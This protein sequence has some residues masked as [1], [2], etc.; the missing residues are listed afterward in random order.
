MNSS[1]S[2]PPPDLAGIITASAPG[3]RRP[4]VW[5]LTATGIILLLCAWLFLGHRG[6]ASHR[7]P[8][9]E[10]EALH[11]SDVRLTITGTGTLQPITQVTVGSELSGLILHV[12]VDTN[13]RV[14]RNQ[15]LAE[16]DTTKLVQQ[17]ENSRASE[18]LAEAAVA[19]A[20]ATVRETEAMRERQRN[21]QQIS[22]GK[23]PSQSDFD[24]AV[25]AADRAEA[26]LK[27]A[28]AQVDQAKAQVRG[29]EYDLD[30]AVIR[31]PIDG[32]VLTRT[33]EPGQTVAASF[34][35]PELFVIAEKLE[36]MTLKVG[37]A[38]ADIGRVKAGDRATFTVDAWPGRLYDA[39]VSKVAFGSAV[40]DN[41]VT[42]QTELEVAN[43]DLSLRPGM[44]A[45]ADIRVAEAH[46][47]FVVS[48]A[49]LRFDPAA[50]RAALA[51]LQAAKAAGNSSLLPNPSSQAGRAPVP[52]SQD[53]INLPGVARI[54]VLQAGRPVPIPVQLGI[55]DGRFTEIQGDR[56]AD[57]LAVITRANASTP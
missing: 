55:S 52:A 47:V 2:S 34:T 27:S 22:G 38:E 1:P 51:I 42:Y 46:Q 20:K 11:R 37:I 19:Q 45:T 53:E 50:A 25:A 3:R 35:A 30:H 29:N 21:L 23:L 56:L 9:F 39:T 40:T 13:D 10:T 17:T 8:P 33:V 24:S 43:D 48:P 54:W 6:T 15:P 4:I 36:K 26:D 49:A 12:F 41:V 28:Q 44:T 31:S 14:S 32:I 7:P 16:L 18:R 57:G 5:K